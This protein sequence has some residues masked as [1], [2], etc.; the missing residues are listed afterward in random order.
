[1]IAMVF[2][3]LRYFN[4]NIFILV[5]PREVIPLSGSGKIN[6]PNYPMSN[7][8]M[9]INCMWK[10]TGSASQKIK[11]AFTDFALSPCATDCNSDSCS[12]SYVELYD[13]G[14]TSSPFLARFCDGSV[15]NE[16]LSKGHEML[17]RFHSEK[18]ADRGFEAEYHVSYDG[19]KG[20]K[21]E[22]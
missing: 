8:T 18:T 1:M 7:Y 16:T 6:S 21:L 2:S 14:S 19:Q 5:C 11:F 17:V 9:Y 4:G 3:P 12:C 20:E 15:L 13:G 22:K 10:I